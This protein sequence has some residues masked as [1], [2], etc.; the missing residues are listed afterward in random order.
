MRDT[1]QTLLDCFVRRNLNPLSPC[2]QMQV[3]QPSKRPCQKDVIYKLQT[4]GLRQL[5]KRDN[6]SQL[7]D[8]PIAQIARFGDLFGGGG[9]DSGES[10]NPQTAMQTSAVNCMCQAAL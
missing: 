5:E 8:I 9:S 4:L 1:P 2:N 10:V 7:T 6:G 3:S